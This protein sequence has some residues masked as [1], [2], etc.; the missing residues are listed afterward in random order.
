VNLRELK[1][2]RAALQPVADALPA[3]VTDLESIRAFLEEIRGRPVRLV[4]CSMP[5]E[6]SAAWLPVPE[7]DLICYERS[8]SPHHQRHLVLHEGAHMLL[9]HRSTA[10]AELTGLLG[11]TLSPKFA[12]SLVCHRMFD[13]AEESQAEVLAVLLEERI[14]ERLRT[15]ASPNEF[16]S[17]NIDRFMSSVE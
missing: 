5:S 13:D 15:P 9:G 11:P 16:A 14:D 7:E 12:G 1:R 6:P 17:R 2:Q 10:A 4:P 3:T 8:T